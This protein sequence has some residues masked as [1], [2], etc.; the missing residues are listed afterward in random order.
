MPTPN[1]YIYITDNTVSGNQIS[2]CTLN[3]KSSGYIMR[4]SCHL[5]LVKGAAKL[6]GS[7]TTPRERRSFS[8]PHP[9]PEILY[10]DTTGLI[11]LIL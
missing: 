2:C 9:G 3:Q 10:Y 1:I 11:Y 7:L 8:E 5:F 4:L 6:N